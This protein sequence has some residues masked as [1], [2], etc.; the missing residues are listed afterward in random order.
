MGDCVQNGK[1]GEVK[2]IADAETATKTEA[3][4]VKCV[5]KICDHGGEVQ[6]EVLED[7]LRGMSSGSVHLRCGD[8]W[9]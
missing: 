6:Q 9:D 2:N 8:R 3:S 1:Q 4:Q 7:E 5:D